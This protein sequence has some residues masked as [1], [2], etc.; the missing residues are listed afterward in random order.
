MVQMIEM[1]FLWFIPL[2]LQL[3]GLTIPVLADSY[4][5][6]KHRSI[7]LVIIALVV[8]LSGQNYLE[9]L[10]AAFRPIPLLRTAVAVYG[11]SVRPVILILF[12]YLVDEKGNYSGAWIAAGINAAVYMTAFFSHI[13]FWISDENHYQEGPLANF[14]LLLST[15]L[16]LFLL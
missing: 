3:I 11:Y 5:S 12:F 8:S 16:I 4:I 13:C 2:A 7:M 14:C 10:L 6:R 1:N 9:D 15:V